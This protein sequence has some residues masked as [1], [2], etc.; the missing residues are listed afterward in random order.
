MADRQTKLDRLFVPL[1]A[2][3]Y[4]NF[5]SGEKD[6]ELRCLDDRFNRRTVISGRRVELRHGYTTDNLPALWGTVGKRWISSSISGLLLSLDHERILPDS[7]RSEFE[8][9]LGTTL[10]RCD[11]YIAFEVD[12]D[13]D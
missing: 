6:V 3:H 4:E 2:E 5:A 7:T 9:S 12:L 13:G 10:G 8:D 11:K 1:K